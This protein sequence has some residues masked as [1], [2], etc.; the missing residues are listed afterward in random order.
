MEN[1]IKHGIA[2]TPGGGRVLVQA[3]LESNRLCL[4][5]ENPGRLEAGTRGH[6]VGLSYLRS[7]LAQ[8]Y[9]HAS[10]SAP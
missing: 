4:V 6:G 2:C 9:N 5:V 3:R 10:W 7:R 1:A 8:I